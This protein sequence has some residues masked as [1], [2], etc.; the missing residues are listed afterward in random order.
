MIE[1]RPFDSL[2]AANH[3]WLDARHHFSFADYRDPARVNW[4]RLRVWNDDRIA[5]NTGCSQSDW[6]STRAEGAAPRS[7][8]PQLALFAT[9]A[10]A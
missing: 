2:G 10:A 8:S 4:G 3:G 6:A 1:L 5:P 9:A 7:A